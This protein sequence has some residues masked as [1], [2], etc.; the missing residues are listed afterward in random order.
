MEV[1]DQVKIVKCEDD[2]AWINEM[3]RLIGQIGKVIGFL[4]HQRETFIRVYFENI[5]REYCFTE[6]EIQK[7]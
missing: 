3:Y 2:D 1:N 5:E 6:N 4:G 7:I